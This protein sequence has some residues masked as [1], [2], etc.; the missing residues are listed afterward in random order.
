MVGE[1]GIAIFLREA[2]ERVLVGERDGG[3]EKLVAQFHP[4][5]NRSVA[6]SHSVFTNN[7]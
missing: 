4:L 2:E 5:L 7:D 1:D 6:I 3:V